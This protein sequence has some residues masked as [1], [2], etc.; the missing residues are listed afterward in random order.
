MRQLAATVCVIALAG[1]LGCSRQCSSANKSYKINTTVSPANEQGR[2]CWQIEFVLEDTSAP[3]GPVVLSAPK[4]LV[5]QGEKGDIF[6][7]DTLNNFRYSAIVNKVDKGL[8]ASTTL[9]VTNNGE[10]VWSSEQTIH[11]SD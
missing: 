1:T 7:G 5:A 10:S 4:I 8:A 2:P 6:V 3:A 11:L 9:T